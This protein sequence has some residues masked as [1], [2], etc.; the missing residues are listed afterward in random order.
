MKEGS[1]DI[2]GAHFTGEGVNF[3]IRSRAATRVDVCLFD[4]DYPAFGGS[5]F[6]GVAS[7]ESFAHVVHGFPQA[8]RIRLP[9][10]AAVFLR[11]AT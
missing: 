7:Y 11:R 8:L 6:A 2:L 1:P 5:G 9:P 10:L 4:S 3:A